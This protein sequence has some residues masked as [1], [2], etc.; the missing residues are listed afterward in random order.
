MKF[1]FNACQEKSVL[2]LKIIID[3]NGKDSEI[4]FVLSL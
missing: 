3:N 4:I 2:F 1:Y